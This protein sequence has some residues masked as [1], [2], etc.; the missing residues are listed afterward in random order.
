MPHCSRTSQPDIRFR[1]QS[2]ETQ[3]QKGKDMPALKWGGWFYGQVN[4]RGRNLKISPP[5]C[6][7]FFGFNFAERELELG[8]AAG[9]GPTQCQGG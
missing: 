6:V 2:A 8:E 9:S 3:T 4:S 5:M 1:K 7:C